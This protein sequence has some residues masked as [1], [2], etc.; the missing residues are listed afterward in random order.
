VFP[1]T[2]HLEN[3]TRYSHSFHVPK[4]HPS[5]I[6]FKLFFH[7]ILDIQRN[8]FAQDI[9]HYKLGLVVFLTPS[10]RLFDAYGLSM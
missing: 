8:T 3:N 4:S 7:L 6:N 10:L 1:K 9:G 2:F 5:K